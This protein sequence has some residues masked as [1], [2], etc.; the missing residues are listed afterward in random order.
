VNGVAWKRKTPL[1]GLITYGEF[2]AILAA[3]F[4]PGKARWSHWETMDG[5]RMAVFTYSIDRAHSNYSLTWCCTAWLKRDRGRRWPPGGAV[6]RTR[7]RRHCPRHAAGGWYIG[8]IPDAQERHGC[9]VS[10]GRHRRESWMCPIRS[11][12]ISDNLKP[13]QRPTSALTTVLPT[14]VFTP[15]N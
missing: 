9:R 12:T 8:W 3:P 14:P 15:T 7:H 5:K 10:E 13:D 4:G 11:I 2:G 1:G 6:H